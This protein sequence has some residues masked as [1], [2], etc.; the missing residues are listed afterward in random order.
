MIS[1][2]EASISDIHK[3]APL[4]DSYRIFY[5][6]K[7]DLT[8]AK[9]FLTQ[10]LEKE[11]SVIFLAKA[12]GVPIGFTQL[13]YTFSSVS[14]EPFL[15]LNDLF[16]HLEYRNRGIG[17]LLLNKA[18]EYCIA[19]KFKGLALETAVDN[20]AQKLYEKLGWKRSTDF[21][22]YFWSAK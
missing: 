10:R 12:D 22:P 18:K 8:S 20:P 17:E 3:I 2:T 15:I 4:F 14:L 16:V 13:Y 6:Q 9:K 21:L 19:S 7:S 5:E 11:E 1:I